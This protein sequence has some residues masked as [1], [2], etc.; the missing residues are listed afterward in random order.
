[1]LRSV[2]SALFALRRVFVNPDIRRAELAWMI[3]YA[4]EWAWLVAL[5]VYA[6][7]VGG[8]A[9]VGLVGVVRTLPA[10]LLAPALS[11]L[12]DHVPRHRVL[13]GVHGGRAALIGLAAVGVALGWPPVVVFV[14]APLDGLLAVLHRPTYMALMPS[15]ARAPE[16]LVA[17]NVASSTL[18]GV[19][20]LIGPAIGGGLVAVGLTSVTF[21]VPAALFLTAAR[22]VLGIRPAQSLRA[23][24]ATRGGLAVLLGGIQALADHPHAG[25]LL[26]LFGGQVV[27]RGVLNVL[28]VAA[29]VQLLALGEEGVGIL[30]AAIGAGG[31]LG[32]LFAMA[33]VGRTRLAPSF[34]L[35][36]AL[37]GTPILLIGLL[38]FSP[39]A[40]LAL[41]VLGAGNAVL[42]VAGF[43][44]LQ[45]SVPNAVRGRVFGLL[46]AIVM[47]GLS[48]GS[49][50]A[51]A[52]VAV[53]G[54]QGALIATGA[55]LPLL[56]IVSWPKVRQID[57]L[58]VIPAR[59]MKL[60]RGVPMF[61]LL[62]LT[63]LE[64]VAGDVAPMQ[65]SA[66]SRIITQ[67]EVGDRF[68]IL[69]E[70]DAE[71]TIDGKAVNHMHSGDSFGEIAL[72]RDVP[73]TAT[74]I[75]ETD[76]V[77]FAIE[78]EAF[79]VAVSGDRQS[80]AAAQAIIGGRLGDGGRL[81]ER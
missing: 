46:E 23:V 24:H 51:P 70:G 61:R 27:V 10:A 13:L 63:V 81:D 55:L 1:M 79:S 21:A 28:L 59:E 14:V 44:L 12:T 52:L 60:L 58:A 41:A 74:V 72:L 62:P 43:S 48:L 42:D 35:G 49:A 75:A 5:F 30:N 32:A 29:S 26:G 8:V 15:L 3:G 54:V 64:Q 19:G 77:A 65:F 34:S 20:T 4:A 56:A 9:A 33:L 31:F 2:S 68:Y 6:F 80:M 71:A 50:V 38:P 25:L 67:G 45:R 57:V 53:L 39:V 73:R 17:S 78:R 40:V 37:W 69:V 7:G 11:S 76:T 66:G 16:E 47:L 36:L 18:E 22:T